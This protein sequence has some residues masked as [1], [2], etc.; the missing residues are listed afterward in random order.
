MK[1]GQV[2][3][4]RTGNVILFCLAMMGA[5]PVFAVTEGWENRVTGERAFKT[6]KL[7]WQGDFSAASGFA[8]EKCDGAEGTVTFGRSGLE[9]RKTNAIG[10]I[11]VRAKGVS[12]PTNQFLRIFADVNVFGADPDF[13]HG[14]VRAHGRSDRSLAV[15]PEA[16]QREM[17]GGWAIQTGLINQPDGVFYRKY[18]HF[19]AKEGYVVPAIVVS[20]EPSVSLWKNFSLE[21]HESA[22]EQWRAVLK[23]SDERR[24]ALPF[25]FVDEDAFARG[26]AAD[27]AHTA[28]LVKRDGRVVVTIDGKA[29]PPVAFKSVVR[30][31]NH[32][33]AAAGMPVVKEGVPFFMPYIEMGTGC[34][35]ED[36]YWTPKGFDAT[37]AVEAVR[38]TM[39]STGNTP[40]IL[41]INCNAYPEFIA[42]EHPDEAWISSPD[43]KVLRGNQLTCHEGYGGTTLKDNSWPWPSM[44]SPSWRGAVKENIRAI[45][46]ELKRTGLSKRIVGVHIMGYND[47]QFGIA[48][49]DYSKWAKAEYEKYLVRHQNASTN[50]VY[51]CWQLAQYA[52]DEFAKAFKDEIG[53]DVIGIRWSDS[54]FMVDFAMHEFT[55]C[56]S[57]DIIVPQPSYAERVPGI[58]GATYMPFSSLNLHGKLMWNELDMRTYWVSCS[59][60]GVMSVLS[61]GNADDFG[62]WQTMYRKYA[63]EMFATRNG[64]WFFDMIRGSQAAPEIAPDIGETMKVVNRLQA[65]RPSNW[66]P[67]VA[68]VIDEEGLLGWGDGLPFQRHT[69]A[70]SHL[71]IR[72]LTGAGVPYEYYLAEDVLQ[73]PELLDGMKTVVFLQWR[74][75]DA[76]R[77]AL[78]KRLAEKPRTLVFLAESGQLGGVREA[79][80]FD[81]K[82]VTHGSHSVR[83]C[84]AMKDLTYCAWD[85]IM[86]RELF[87]TTK[88]AIGQP[89]GRRGNIVEREGVEVLGR[90]KDD[91]A[92]SIATCRHGQA[93]S[94]YV[95]APGGLTPGFFNRLCRESGA[96]VP[97]ATNRLQVNM[98]G[99]FISVHALATGHF[100]FKLPFPAKVTNVKSGKEEPVKNGMLPLDLSAGETCWFYLDRLVENSD[101]ID[102]GGEWR[103][104]AKG[105][106]TTV[107]LPG[108]LGGEKIGKRWVEE[109]FR[110][111]MDFPQMKA[112]SQECQFVGEA[113][114]KREID[115]SEGDC[116]HDLELYLDRVMWSCEVFFD[117]KSLGQ[118]DSLATAHVHAL[119]RELLTPGRH[120]IKLVI[121]NSSRYGFSRYSHSYGPSMQAVWNG[122]L[123]K[124][125]LRRAHPLREARVFASAP[126]DG[127]LTVE[128]PVSYAPGLS[129]IRIEGLKV[130]GMSESASPYRSGFKMIALQLAEEPEYWTDAHPRL[131]ELSLKDAEAGFTQRIRFGFRSIGKRGHLLTLNG[132]DFFLRGNI[133]NA[134]FARDGL[135]WTAV[136]DWRRIW[137]MLKREDGINA[138]RFHS[139]CPPEAAFAAADELGLVMMPEADIWTDGWMGWADEVGNGKPVD[140]YVQWELRNILA[141]YGNHPSFLSLAIGNELGNSNFETMGHWMGEFKKVDSRHLYFCATARKQP[142]EDDFAVTHMLPDGQWCRQKLFNNTDWDYEAVYASAKI[143]TVAHEIGQWSVYPV[144]SDMLSRF[145]GD[146]RPWNLSRHFDTA[147]QEGTLRFNREFHEASAKLSRLIYKEEV[148]SFLRTPSCAGV[149]LLNAQDFTGQGEALVGWRGPFYDLKRAYW[150]APAFGTVWGLTNYLARTPK[151]CCTVG[152][153][154]VARLQMRNLTDRAFPAGASFS[155]ELAGVRGQV[156]TAQAIDP[157]ALCDLGEVKVRVTEAMTT[158]KQT[159]SFGSNSWPFWAFPA[160]GR[161]V[162]PEGVLLTSD[163][164]AMKAAVRAGK[165]VLYTGPSSDSVAGTFKPVYW[166]ANWFAPEEV[167]SAALG[168]WFDVTHPALRGFPT[169]DFTDWQW[170]D[171]AEG[172]RI[173]RL[174][175]MP[176]DYRPIGLSVNDF[177]FSIFAATIFEA[178]V[179]NGRVLICG[180]DLDKDIP[181]ARRL[182]ATLSA[183]LAQPAPAGVPVMAD[184]W[185]DLQF[186]ASKPVR[187]R[188]DPVFDK[189]YEWSGNDFKTIL[190]GFKPVNGVIKLQM[191]QLSDVA[192]FCRGL[193]DGH[194]FTTTYMSG[195]ESHVVE[196]PI[197]REDILDGKVEMELHRMMGYGAAVER[198]TIVPFE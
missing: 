169:E 58:G 13:S 178:R 23:R 167:L 196:I 65:K 154:F 198:I 90:F 69:Y 16:R 121:D 95:S 76:R 149:E 141:A 98:N 195:K 80:G 72:Q 193:V 163:R 85:A 197:Q 59:A 125:A 81:V 64:F 71:Q 66:R 38:Y 25:D 112:L 35:P 177:H 189:T 56:D 77:I 185:L 51:F 19:L 162:M 166:S 156:K 27:V 22:R 133:E 137:D 175:G 168:A 145:T 96:Y 171:L 191:R 37:G 140:K 87:D 52:Q 131:Y 132:D 190:T 15:Q 70:L 28:K 43:G 55:E 120:E 153:D 165:A 161:C 26:L 180:Y 93:R 160:E 105:I 104:T 143:P 188:G 18:A 187:K 3:T 127:K 82:F 102:L 147:K 181:A 173:H 68:L 129:D 30:H 33:D 63:G 60:N 106:D 184:A 45:V 103:V 32:S 157:G 53:K 49:A 152:G 75:F 92:P 155:Y 172:G 31:F 182:R 17:I 1:K 48:H 176:S 11:A 44:A 126:A 130:V 84:G 108:T 174:Y 194:V 14:F 5:L 97:V 62:E 42:V 67:E 34:S 134:N 118:N 183:Y 115:L 101:S 74:K 122:V 86:A 150:N 107:G 57:L 88:P 179:G 159:L 40:A 111:S 158:S 73:R 91:G 146:M 192:S 41:A 78:A 164:V 128:V 8:V 116:K 46:R 79:T 10:Y 39:R 61:A 2:L 50:Y 139:W 109:D 123:G 138:I 100:D 136:A 186:A 148:E 21:D 4:L 83:S 20:G 99:D 144:W 142:P 89:T 94:V 24:A 114:Y 170:F 117:G 6:G 29:V 135:P 151:F 36:T 119:P 113:V 9:I 47:G 110:T 54:P 124:L 7:V 12:V